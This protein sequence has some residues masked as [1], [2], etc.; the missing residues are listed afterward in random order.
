MVFDIVS[1]SDRLDW[2]KNVS[3]GRQHLLLHFAQRCKVLNVNPPGCWRGSPYLDIAHITDNLWHLES[4]KFW[5]YS[6]KAAVR[7]FAKWM[8]RMLVTYL[9]E[10]LGMR[11][12]VYLVWWPEQ[13]EAVEQL[14]PRFTVYYA[15][16]KYTSY[17]LPEDERRRLASE[18]L[19]IIKRA[20]VVFGVSEVLCDYLREIGGR[21][22]Y[23]M[24]NGVRI[25]PASSIENAPPDIRAVKRP[26]MGFVG[27]IYSKID[28]DILHYLA[29]NL[30][31]WSLVIVGDV[32]T[33]NV[34]RQKWETL[35]S[36]PNVYA[37]GWKSQSNVAAY[38]K[39]LDVG[40]MPTRADAV[41]AYYTS[42]LKVYDY[43]AVGIPVVSSPIPEVLKMEGL[44]YTANTPDEWVQAVRR[45]VREDCSHL[46]EKRLQFARQNTWDIRAQGVLEIMQRHYEECCQGRGSI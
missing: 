34:D 12:P 36:F 9:C 31:D 20:H 2:A 15:Y 42:P 10:R 4:S 3:R 6:S 1:F 43:L 16:D 24:P 26:R 21:N 38:I 7:P 8:R 23:Y 41:H 29:K 46:R 37:L 35:Q 18:E 32:R 28:I 14:S 11:N 27:S 25:P 19:R 45:A 22:V 44:V 5:L 17:R 40:L 33:Q 30:V 13:A 39:E